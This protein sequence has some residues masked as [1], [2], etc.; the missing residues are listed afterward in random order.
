MTERTPGAPVPASDEHGAAW[1]DLA[2]LSSDLAYE[3]DAA[4]RFVSLEPDKVLGWRAEELIGQPA[5]R[6]LPDSAP[7]DPFRVPAPVRR[8]RAALR[9]ADGG[10]VHVL[11]TAA[12][13]LDARGTPVGTRGLA[14]DVTRQEAR[15]HAIGDERRRTEI[16]GR[17]LEGLRRET[18]PARRMQSALDALLT[19]IGA[20]GI[21]VAEL[22]GKVMP[23]VVRHRGGVGH[24]SLG[25]ALA[26]LDLDDPDPMQAVSADGRPV[27]ACPAVTRF[28]ERVA[29]AAWRAPNAPAWTAGDLQL[30]GWVTAVVGTV[31]EHEAMQREM[32]RQVRNDPLTGLLNRRAFLEDVARR[33]DRLDREELNG[34]LLLID[35][36]DFAPLGRLGAELGD[37][38][39]LLMTRLLRAAVRPAD[40]LARL[41]GGGFA[42]WMDGA[43]ELT[44]AERAEMLRIQ[45]PQELA[46]LITAPGLPL[47]VSIGIACR[48]PGRGEELDSLMRRASL[49][50]ENA[51][52]GG[53]RVSHDEPN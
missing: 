26:G 47:T 10:I 20:E 46:S 29:L 33:I 24:E 45:A 8:R 34:T 28:G 14:Q 43:D 12:P 3:V 1:R 15:D 53:W 7:L 6:L 19:A 2:G 49:A 40:L 48:R 31:L 50:L 23:P 32:S 22:F 18:L 11:V 36:D 51:K 42:A 13:L 17:I 38:A 9:A 52:H 27:L 39:L 30:A 5:S 41:G 44:S 35:L 25:S 4:G 21:A 16:F 37:E